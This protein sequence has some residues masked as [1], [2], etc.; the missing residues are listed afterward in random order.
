[1]PL[2]GDGA[3]AELAFAGVV[4]ERRAVGVTAAYPS[5][6][7]TW[8]GDRALAHLELPTFNCLSADAP[9]DPAAAGCTRSVTEY[10]DLPS[11]ALTV[12]RMGNR[13]RISGPF[14]TYL[15]PNGTPPVW[16]GRVYEVAVTVGPESATSGRGW[17]PAEATVRLGDE[18][19]ATAD[20]RTG[21]IRFGD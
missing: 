12:H 9:E 2:S 21:R 10:A 16:T 13:L 7:L 15:R 8:D 1:M 18:R 14:A 3:A 5:L 20:V 19:A 17:Q 6:T 11:P 4:L